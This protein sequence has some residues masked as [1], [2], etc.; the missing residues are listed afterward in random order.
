MTDHRYPIGT[1]ERRD[2]LTPDE[3]R[4][5][6]AQLAEA[7][8]RMREAVSGLGDERLDTPYRDGGWTVRQV[9]HHVPDSHLNAYCRLKIALT[10]DGTPTIR[11]YDEASWAKLPDM[12]STP[13]EVSLTLLESLHARWVGLW[14]SMSDADF[15]RTFNHPEHGVRSV[16]WLLALY[17]WH[18]R[19]HVAH[20]TAL[21]ERMRW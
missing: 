10:E 4:T 15:E 17:A 11:P 21:R 5:F 20:I 1:F 19:H 12:R 14:Q 16:D 2:T 9:V 6:I 13:T 18:G 8:A 7:P 3:R